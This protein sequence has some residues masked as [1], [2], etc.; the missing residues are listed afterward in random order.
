MKDREGAH[1]ELLLQ[2]RQKWEVEEAAAK[3]ELKQE[4][5]EFKQEIVEI[6]KRMDQERAGFHKQMEQEKATFKQ[7]VDDF[8]ERREEMIAEMAAIQKELQIRNVVRLLPPSNKR[9]SS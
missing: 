8:Q 3:T 9:S 7:K 4:N 2:R 1:E 6:R 5:T